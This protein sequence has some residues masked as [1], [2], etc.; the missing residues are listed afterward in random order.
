MA[1]SISLILNAS[2]RRGLKNLWCSIRYQLEP[3]PRGS[4][5]LARES[6]FGKSLIVA[7]AA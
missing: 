3:D 6:H 5:K 4:E 7:Q 1:T 2:I